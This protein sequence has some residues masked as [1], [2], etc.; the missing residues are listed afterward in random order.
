MLF[1]VTY[2]LMLYGIKMT[3]VVINYD[4][5]HPYCSKRYIVCLKFIIKELVFRVDVLTTSQKYSVFSSGTKQN[6]S[7]ICPCFN[8]IHFQWTA[9]FGLQTPP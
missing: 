5:F 9:S 7:A 2:R 4:G 8:L 6:K 3:G 1:N